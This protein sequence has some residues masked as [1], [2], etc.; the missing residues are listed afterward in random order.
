[1][2]NEDST[3]VRAAGWSAYVSSAVSALGVAFLLLLYLGFL[4]NLES[5]L[6]FGP[7][8]DLL[9][10]VQYLLALPVAVALYQILKAQSAGMSLVAVLAAFVGIVGVVVFTSLLIAGV[11]T[12]SEQVGYV[13][14]FLLVVGVWIVITGLLGRRG[15]LRL[16]IPAIILGALYVG[17]PLWAYRVG[18]QLLASGGAAREGSA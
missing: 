2:R 10:I 6:V 17:F 18:Q 16:S 1:M 5:L 15:K 14:A 13:S 4:A 9:V 7:L 3:L 11:M 12:F 8:N